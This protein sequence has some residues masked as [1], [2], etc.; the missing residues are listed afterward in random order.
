M[1]IDYRSLMWEILYYGIFIPYCTYYGRSVVVVFVCGGCKVVVVVETNSKYCSYLDVTRS[2]DVTSMP[3]RRVLIDRHDSVAAGVV[4]RAFCSGG[5]SFPT[6]LRSI[7]L[8]IAPGV[9]K[10]TR[11]A[12]RNLWREF[13]CKSL[14]NQFE[15]QN[16]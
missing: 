5:A 10:F 11:E 15:T 6:K 12:M 14:L 4:R 9:L 2:A 1:N 13:C 3:A 8:S 7:S 16:I